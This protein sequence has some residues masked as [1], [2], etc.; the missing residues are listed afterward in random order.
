MHAAI[1]FKSCVAI[2]E[3]TWTKYNHRDQFLSVAGELPDV[4]YW[5]DSDDGVEEDIQSYVSHT[6]SSICSDIQSDDIESDNDVDAVVFWLVLFT[7]LIQTL[8]GLS[9]R[10]MKWM[11]KMIS[12]LLSYLGSFS[13]NI[14][15]MALKFPSTLHQRNVY[16]REKTHLPSIE[17]K[18][19]CSHCH[20]LYR[21]DECIDK[22]GCSTYVKTCMDSQKNLP[23]LREIK[24]RN[25]SSKF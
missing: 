25:G 24:T 21:Y 6:F 1:K 7:C 2:F 19:A 22:R 20:A 12:T 13:N 18:V 11:L 17:Q 4:E 5:N 10:S 14:V 16:L 3:S 23:L 9:T 15:D 8:H